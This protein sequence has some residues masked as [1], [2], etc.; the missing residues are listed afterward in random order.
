MV[1]GERVV[2]SGTL[3]R[4]AGEGR[5]GVVERRSDGEP[6]PGAPSV[7]CAD[8]FPAA[9]ERVARAQAGLFCSRNSPI[10]T[11]ARWMFSVE[12]A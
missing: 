8:I 9:R 6:F 3:S 10:R 5:E 1:A 12:L 2:E 4:V 11:S 7:G